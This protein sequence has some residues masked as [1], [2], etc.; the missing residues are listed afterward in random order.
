MSE[1]PS[2]ISSRANRS[3][4]VGRVAQS[5][6]LL[7]DDDPGLVAVVRPLLEALRPRR[8]AVDTAV[9]QASTHLDAI[10]PD[11]LL[12]GSRGPAHVGLAVLADLR[13][14][15]RWRDLPVIVLVAHGDA[16]ARRRAFALGA[17]DFVD[18]SPDATDL[19]W[20]LRNALGFKAYQDRLLRRDP[21][22]GLP[23]RAEFLR[24]VQSVLVRAAADGGADDSR[25]VVVLDIDRF[26]QIND[27]LGHA[28]GDALLVA[29]AQRLAEVM[30][31]SV[32]ADRR[33]EGS[34]TTPWLARTDRDRFLALLPGSPGAPRHD[35]AVAALLAAMD[36]PF[37]L[38]RREFH[39]ST[40]LGIAWYPAHGERAEVLMQHA[41]IALEQAKRRGGRSVARF[42]PG[43]LSRANERLAMENQLHY[44]IRRDELCLHYQPKVDCATLRM[45]GVESLI[46]WQHPDLGLLSPQRFI[47]LAEEAGLIDAIGEWAIREACRQGAAWMKAGLPILDVAV[48]LSAAQLL[49]G[50]FAATVARSLSDSGFDPRR[51]TLELTESM[52]M[53]AGDQGRR[54]LESVKALGV[55]LSLDDFGTGYS[56]LTYLRQLPIDEI[57]ID[58]SFVHGLPAARQNAAIAAAVIQLAGA[59]GL[60]AVAEGVESTAELTFLRRFPGCRF[61]GYLFSKP[62][63]A[64]ALTA[65]LESMGA[66]SGQ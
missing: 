11:V 16:E 10:E 7:L 43:M 17:S 37:H 13:G 28:A 48:N 38:D 19:H 36:R 39:L 23:N 15:E 58:R 64:E 33:A 22:T 54:T 25:S 31:S 35:A 30:A 27:G 65:M 46:R 52:L 1:L 53:T 61:Q 3:E 50:D 40:S 49:R 12:L 6:I 5:A 4:D 2:A 42:G 34:G 20:R 21:L 18:R 47:P 14:S 24:R 55:A 66:R 32:G 57:K 62:V 45:V 29:V 63:A 60:Q 8:L 26:R 56:P 51:L 9:E 59:L 44:A 41:E